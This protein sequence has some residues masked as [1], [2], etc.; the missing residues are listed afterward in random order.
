MHIEEDI[1]GAELS[2]GKVSEAEVAGV[3]GWSQPGLI[4]AGEFWNHRTNPAWKQ[5]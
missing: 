5:G 1:D 4:P 2:E 3:G